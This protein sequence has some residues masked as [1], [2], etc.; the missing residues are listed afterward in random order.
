MKHVSN[1]KLEIIE[2]ESYFKEKRFELK[3]ITKEILM[4]SEELNNI[5]LQQEN[6]T[7]VMLQLQNEILNLNQKYQQLELIKNNLIQILN[8]K[9]QSLSHL[10]N[11]LIEIRQTTRISEDG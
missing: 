5:T 11:D 7:K 9:L 1:L 3:D 4:K 6:D 2:N 10:E 8:T